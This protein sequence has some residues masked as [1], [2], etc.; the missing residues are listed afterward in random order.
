MLRLLRLYWVTD[1]VIVL[2]IVMLI[3]LLGLN[4]T[5][6]HSR[7]FKKKIWTHLLWRIKFTENFDWNIIKNTRNWFPAIYLLQSKL[8]TK[9]GPKLK[10]SNK[11]ETTIFSKFSINSKKK[12]SLAKLWKIFIDDLNFKFWNKESRKSKIRVDLIASSCKVFS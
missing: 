5:R 4:L 11:K 3:K 10:L 9:T 12:A 1:G 2:K 6:E 8:S 7:I